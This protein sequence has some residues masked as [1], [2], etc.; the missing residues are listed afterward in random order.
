MR[1]KFLYLFKPVNKTSFLKNSF[2]W[3]SSNLIY[4]IIC[5]G[6][7]KQSIAETGGLVKQRISIN[8]QHTRQSQYQQL[9]VEDYLYTCGEGMFHMFSFFK[10]FQENKSLRKSYKNYVIDKFKPFLNKKT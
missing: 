2:N 10:I 1:K 7:K 4:I 5:Q 6:C 8:R 3:E 9:A